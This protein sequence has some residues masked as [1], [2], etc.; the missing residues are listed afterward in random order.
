MIQN[1]MNAFHLPIQAVLG[2]QIGFFDRK[3][4]KNCVKNQIQILEI[5][6]RIQIR[7]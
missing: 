7:E 1:E 3:C 4:V 6:C 5:L 2:Q